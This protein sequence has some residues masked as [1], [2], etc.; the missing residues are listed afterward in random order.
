MAQGWSG[1]VATLGA[2]VQTAR[3]TPATNPVVKTKFISGNVKPQ[4]TVQ[5]LSETAATRDVGPSYKSSESV[6]GNPAFYLR[7]DDFHD[8]IYYALGTNV[9]SGAGPFVHTATPTAGDLPY[10]TLFKMLAS[11]TAGGGILEKHSDCKVN[12]LKISAQNGQPATVELDIMGL[13]PSRVPTND[14]ITVIAS[15]PYTFDQLTVSK[16]GSAISTLQS[17]DLTIANNLQLMQGNGSIS[18]FDIFPGEVQISGSATLLYQ[19]YGNYAAFH[20]GKLAS[21]TS[22]GAQSISAGTINI[23]SNAGF[24][25]AGTVLILGQQISYTSTTST[26]L[27]GCTGG[28]GGAGTLPAATPVVQYG[29]GPTRTLFQE[30][31]IFTLTSGANSVAITTTNLTYTDVPVEPDAS[32]APIQSALAFTVEPASPTISIATTNA[33]TTIG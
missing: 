19:D 33:V 17:F 29:T 3:G 1:N 23:A 15:F 25:S 16:G 10:V 8:W 24:L 13:T 2:A 5:R 6:V 7:P 14:V 31:W 12:S 18:P 9:D 30:P 20:Y 21:T 26:T 22:T 32:G 27:A 4:S 28:V 11:A